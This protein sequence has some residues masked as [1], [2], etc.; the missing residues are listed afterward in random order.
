MAQVPD[1]FKVSKNTLSKLPESERDGAG[2]YLWTKSKG[3]CALCDQ[4]LPNEAGLI[5]EGEIEADHHVPEHSGAGGAT[6]LKNLY[7]AH[8]SCNRRRRDLPFGLAHAVI[9]FATWV[10]RKGRVT[11]EDVVKKYV[12]SPKSR[13]A[14]GEGRCRDRC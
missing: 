7:L 3:L 14:R 13:R 8:K 12:K 9:E 6:E 11:F 10:D 1:G 5:E 2:S 4:P